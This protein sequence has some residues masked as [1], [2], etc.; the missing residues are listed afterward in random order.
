MQRQH[1]LIGAAW[2]THAVAWFLPVAAEGRRSLTACPAGR[3]SALHHAACGLARTFKFEHWYNA[4]FATISAA[5]T[6]LYVLGS[7]WVVL[8]GSHK[9]RRASA[10][11]ATA[12]F[13]INAN[14]YVLF[15]PDRKDLMIGYFLWWLSFL[16][17]TFGLLAVDSTSTSGR[18]GPKTI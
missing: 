9:V 2:L 3:L 5:T 6:A 14:W 4:V 15:G 17:L 1:V 13:V 11:I 7:V 10:W 12:A 18:P 16:L 8:F